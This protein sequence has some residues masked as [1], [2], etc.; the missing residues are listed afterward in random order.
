MFLSIKHSEWH[1]KYMNGEIDYNTFISEY[2]NPKNYRPE[3]VSG[4]RSHKYK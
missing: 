1:K 3:S 4:N 2:W